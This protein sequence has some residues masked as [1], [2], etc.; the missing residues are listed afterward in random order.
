MKTKTIKLYDS[1]PYAKS[2]SAAVLSCVECDGGYNAVLDRTVF[3]PEEGGQSCDKGKI[4]GIDVLK[5]SICDGAI[6]H[7]L[8]LPVEKGKTVCGEIDFRHRYRNMQNHSGEHIF[9]GIV[10]KTFGFDNVGFHLGSCDM[11]MDYNG[12]LTAENIAAVED[13]VNAAIYENVE[14]I[15]K[16]YEPRDLEG[17]MYRSKLDLASDI[18]IVTVGDYDICACCAPHVARTGEI[19]ILKVTDFYRYKGGTRVHALCGTDALA[20]YRKKHDI[21]ASLVALLSSKPADILQSVEHVINQNERLSADISA[22]TRKYCLKIAEA[23]PEGADS[24]IFFDENLTRSGMQTIA[25]EGAK[26][27][28]WCAVFDKTAKNTFNMIIASQSVSAKAVLS[29]LSEKF[30][31]KGGGSDKM[32]QGS[33]VGAKKE[34]AQFLETISI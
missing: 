9:S 24:A 34:I 30:G 21:A 5:V 8:T 31:A 33:V 15:A 32:V 7:F 14:I 25:N 2:F 12:E 6:T 10:H 11:T 26:K 19:G 29:A 28:K 23:I 17:L 4:D 20:D 13:A 1:D 3:F 18:R 27:A 16:Y 22:V